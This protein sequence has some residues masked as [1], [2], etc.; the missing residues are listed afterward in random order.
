MENIGISRQPLDRCSA[1]VS[2][3]VASRVIQTAVTL[4]G[5]PQGD[6]GEGSTEE[7]DSFEGSSVPSRK[8]PWDQSCKGVQ[9]RG[10]SDPGG[11]R[12]AVSVAP[13]STGDS[14]RT[15]YSGLRRV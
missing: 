1:R 9:T 10:S 11:G 5:A 6:D 4:T 3:S 2:H 8:V 12:V 15:G 14:G 13:R 7:A